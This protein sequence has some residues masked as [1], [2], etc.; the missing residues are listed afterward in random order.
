[1]CPL[2][3]R[4]KFKKVQ[5]D[6]CGDLSS[7]LQ[8]TLYFVFVWWFRMIL[9]CFL[10]SLY[11]KCTTGNRVLLFIHAD[12]LCLAYKQL[13]LLICLDLGLP[14]YYT[15]LLFLGSSFYLFF[16]NIW[17]AFSNVFITY[18]KFLDMLLC[19]IFNGYSRDYTIHT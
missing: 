9:F 16:W 5:T 7:L 17:I 8:S 11:L 4:I 3:C 15:L 10:A 12:N 13:K 14:F 18:Y 1:M 2:F 6:F 19:I